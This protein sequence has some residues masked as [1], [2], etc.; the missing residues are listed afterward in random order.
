[1]KGVGG[2]NGWRWIFILEGLLTVVM[3]VAAY[4]WVYN[5]PATAEFLSE[6]ERQFIHFRL[7]NDNDSTREE[8]FTWSAVMDAFKDPKVWLYGLGFHTM[9]LPLYTLSLFMVSWVFYMRSSS[10]S[11]RYSPQSSNNS[12]T[13]PLKPSFSPFHPTPWHSSYRSSLLYSL[14]A[15]TCAHHSSWAPPDS[16]LSATFSSSPKTDPESPTW[17][18]SSPQQ[19]S[20]PPWPSSSPGR[21]TT[22]QDKQ[23]VPSPTPCRS[24]SEILVPSWEHNCIVQSHHRDTSWAMDL[25]LDILWLIS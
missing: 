1:M 21:P 20:I 10:R 4:F 14:N 13:L 5:Y 23:N 6:E 3:S 18:P 17:A 24:P 22:S 9:A 25:R 19:V 15:S 11:D 2:Y 12:D 7:K 8:K 16:P